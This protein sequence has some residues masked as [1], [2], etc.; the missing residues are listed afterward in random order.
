MKE[1]LFIHLIKQQSKIL[2]FQLPAF[3]FS[4]LFSISSTFGRKIQFS[5]N[6]GDSYTQNYFSDFTGSDLI[7]GFLVWLF[8]YFL[9]QILSTSIEFYQKQQ[10]RDLIIFSFK[11]QFV[12]WGIGFIL[13]LLAW[14][15]YLL[16]LAPGSV[17]GDSLLSI[18]QALGYS[19][20]NNHHPIAYTLFVKVFIRIGLYFNSLNLGIFLYSLTQSM[21]MAS[22]LSFSFVWLYKKGISR[23]FLIVAGIYYAILP[24]F[25]TYGIIM[26]KDPLFSIAL[27]LMS[28]LLYD[29]VD[30][31][32]HLL[33][34]KKGY[35]LYISITLV[36][37]FFR[38]NG[39]YVC[40]LSLM[41]LILI[42]RKKLFRFYLVA[43]V[44][45]GLTMW[46]QGPLYQ[47]LE[48]E[49]ESVEA[50]G[51]PLQQ[52]GRV[53]ALGKDLTK[54][55]EEFLYSLLPQETYK[56]KY[57]PCLVDTLKWDPN[58]NQEFLENNKSLFFK[59]WASMLIP[60]FSEYVKAYCLETF[61]FWKMGVQND[62]GYIDT[63]ISENSVGI[64]RV[65]LFEKW[66]GI[67]LEPVLKNFKIYIGSGTLAFI[68]LWTT[69]MLWSLKS[70]KS[71]LALLPSLITWL[72][73]LIAT[74]VAFSLRY[75]YI[76]PLALPLFIAL[77][78]LKQKNT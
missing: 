53:A 39:I 56:E 59:T 31:D 27:L 33:L 35:F 50:L 43:I 40:F 70:T 55:Q 26:W 74:P 9:F 67:S 44:F 78:F 25:P 34:T 10:T 42:Y 65:D 22:A 68:M 61:G 13:I 18:G 36:V 66:F 16:A 7:L 54:E 24:I 19:P 5:G 62:Y 72:V 48:I 57:T 63:Y 38:N 29:V 3:F 28:L 12:L 4:L 1:K 69:F 21:L 11:K 64:Y 15:P 37:S 30:S 20:L 51:I 58:F 46:I 75:V 49:Q 6:V 47:A 76:L 8:I 32:G 71:I 52:M 45:L 41:F 77:P 17:L 2:S 73:I 23:W 14:S 60:N